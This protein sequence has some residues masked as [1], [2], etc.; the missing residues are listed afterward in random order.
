MER[1]VEATPALRK[2]TA[3][4]VSLWTRNIQTHG[5][6]RPERRAAPPSCF[7]SNLCGQRA[8]EPNLYVETKTNPSSS[9]GAKRRSEDPVEIFAP[10]D[11]LG[12]PVKPE[13]DEGER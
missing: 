2:R 1:P 13:D 10:H 8:V 5:N 9:D 12:P 6:R 3:R 11:P 4:R 7:F